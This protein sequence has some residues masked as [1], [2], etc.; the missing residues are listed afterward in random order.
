MPGQ[1]PSSY[2]GSLLPGHT[3]WSLLSSLLEDQGAETTRSCYFQDRW[4]DLQD[5]LCGVV[6]FVGGPRRFLR[7]L[8]DWDRET[9]EN[10]G[11]QENQEIQNHPGS[12]LPVLE[13]AVRLGDPDDSGDPG[14][15]ED[16]GD[17]YCPHPSWSLFFLFL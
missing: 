6:T 11:T 14:N 3:Y 13:K 7:R 1:A 9:Q 12:I 8:S 17:I 5:R 10:R 16:P 15:P 4:Y 2:S